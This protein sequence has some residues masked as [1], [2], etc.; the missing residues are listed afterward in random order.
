MQEM[1]IE[2]CY[3]VVALSFGS[4]KW[5]AP[6][7]SSCRPF[8]LQPP[9]P[10]SQMS[11]PPN[12]HSPIDLTIT[13][14]KCQVHRND[15]VSRSLD[16]GANLIELHPA[17]DVKHGCS[18]VR[19]PS[20]HDT[21]S[22]KLLVDRYDARTLLDEMSLQQLCNRHPSQKAAQPVIEEEGSEASRNF[23]RYGMLPEY[24][25]CFLKGSTYEKSADG[26]DKVDSDDRVSAHETIEKEAPFQLREEQLKGLP[27]GIILVSE[28]YITVGD[29]GIAN[30]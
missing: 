2:R 3:L 16:D 23:E 20:N 17:D 28:I 22:S 26:V 14:K 30:R 8:P 15:R 9:Q 4:Y 12:K 13:G 18:D 10:I 1:G 7:S 27:P 11:K 19:R 6:T 5:C 24:S 21:S 29:G 25:S